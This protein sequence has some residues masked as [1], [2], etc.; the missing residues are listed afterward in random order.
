MSLHCYTYTGWIWAVFCHAKRQRRQRRPITVH[1]RAA[2]GK[3]SF[4]CKVISPQNVRSRLSSCFDWRCPTSSSHHMTMTQHN[5]SHE[6]LHGETF[7]KWIKLVQ[8][9]SDVFFAPAGLTARLF[10]LHGFHR[11]I[12]FLVPSVSLWQCRQTNADDVPD[13]LCRI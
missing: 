9:I 3:I 1:F 8:S 2:F 4:F 13:F 6:W 7:L 5:I 10:K 12:C 11:S